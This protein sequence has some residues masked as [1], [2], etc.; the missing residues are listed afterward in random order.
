M[1]DRIKVGYGKQVSC[2]SIGAFYCD[3]G[4]VLLEIE[5]MDFSKPRLVDLAGKT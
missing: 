2:V 5:T 4:Y 3:N 1:V